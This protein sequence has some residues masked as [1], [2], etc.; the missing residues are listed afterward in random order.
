MWVI[1]VLQSLGTHGVRMSTL[2]LVR[3]V[4]AVFVISEAAF[5]A[6]CKATAPCKRAPRTAQED[7][8]PFSRGISIFTPALGVGWESD[9]HV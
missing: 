5:P 2:H 4:S 1:F 3:G 6:P 9:K 8:L 7:P